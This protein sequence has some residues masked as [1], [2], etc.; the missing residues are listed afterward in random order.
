[1]GGRKSYNPKNKGKKSY[2][3]ILTFLSETREYISG[4]LR[5]GDRP[6]GAQNRQASGKRMGSSA[7]DGEDDLCAGRCG[8]LLLGGGGSLPEPGG[9]V[10]H[11]R[12]QDVSFGRGAES[13]Q[14][15]TLA[16]HGRRR[17]MRVLLPAGGLG[18][19]LSVHRPALPEAG[20]TEPSRRARA[21]PVVRQAGVQLSRVRHPYDGRH[22]SAGVVLPSTSRRRESDQ[23]SP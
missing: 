7:A 8:V 10:H 4:E 1:M 21:V 5:N 15:A 20:A 9:A 13:R 19:S 6:T 14:L 2:L 23:G 16:A 18:E 12:A 11:L 3:P 22:L 17:T